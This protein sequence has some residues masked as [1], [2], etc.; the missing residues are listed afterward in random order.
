MNYYYRNVIKVMDFPSEKRVCS[1]SLISHEEC[2]NVFAEYLTDNGNDYS[3][4][5]NE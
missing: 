5:V 1:S 2:Y 3:D 4:S